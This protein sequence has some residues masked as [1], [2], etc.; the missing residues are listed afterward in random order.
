MTNIQLATIIADEI[1]VNNVNDSYRTDS[2][3]IDLDA[4]TN[5]FGYVDFAEALTDWFESVGNDE[6]YDRF[7]RT[8][9]SF[10]ERQYD[11]LCAKIIRVHR[12]AK[13][14]R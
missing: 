2:P 14:D 13:E 6:A 8:S 9:S 3:S 5:D 1:A 7:L 11:R 12:L 10:T 4:Y